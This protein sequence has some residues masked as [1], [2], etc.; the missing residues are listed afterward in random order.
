MSPSAARTKLEG[1]G[2]D[3]RSRADGLCVQPLPE[4]QRSPRIGGPRCHSKIG[5][6]AGAKV[7][8]D[9]RAGKVKFAGSHDLRRSFGE[10]WAPRVMPQVLIELMRDESIDTT[11]RF[12]V[13]RK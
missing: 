12:F 13:G 10:R 4:S 9:P 11:L 7:N 6:T 3:P 8:T 5:E 2:A 1:S